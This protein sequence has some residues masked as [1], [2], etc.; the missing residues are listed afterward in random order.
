[1]SET[2]STP[3]AVEKQPDFAPAKEPA[4]TWRNWWQTAQAVETSNGD[5]VGDGAVFMDG[6]GPYASKEIAETVAAKQAADDLRLHKRFR[7]IHL[8]AFPEG[9]RP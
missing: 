3:P 5:W 2:I 6:Y 1:M 9:Q 4:K 8:G 7:G